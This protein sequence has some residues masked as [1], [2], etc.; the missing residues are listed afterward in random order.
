[1]T[2]KPEVLARAE[3]RLT[4]HIALHGIDGRALAICTRYEI[5]YRNAQDAVSILDS[6]RCLCRE[7]FG[8]AC[9]QPLGHGDDHDR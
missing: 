8:P 1:M 4:E 9:L 7:P 3:K 2:S 6:G 5:E